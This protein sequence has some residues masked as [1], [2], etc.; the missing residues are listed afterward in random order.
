MIDTKIKTRLA[1]LGLVAVLGSGCGTPT[2]EEQSKAQVTDIQVPSVCTEVKR[3][4][5]EGRSTLMAYAVIDCRDKEGYRMMCITDGA[6]P[7]CY[8]LMEERK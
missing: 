8:R 4:D 3:L 1:G 2:I 6:T 7:R 5:I